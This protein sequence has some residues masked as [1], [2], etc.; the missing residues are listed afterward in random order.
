MSQGVERPEALRG[1]YAHCE[2]LAREGERDRWLSA[3]FAGEAAR[4]HFHAL[5]AFDH[6]IA[7]IRIV[8]RE[9][10]A[11]EM[12][13]AWWREAIGGE[14]DGEARAHPVGAALM[15]TIEAF[16]LPRQAFENLLLARTFDLYDDPMPTWRDLEGYCGE[17]TSILFQCAALILGEGRDL[18]A[19]EA[20]GHAGVAAGVTN[21]L[22]RFAETSARGQVYLPIEVLARHDV[23]ADDVRAR[24]DSAGLRAVLAELAGKARRHLEEAEATLA[25]LP[26][27]VIPAY[28]PLGALR[29]DLARLER[30]RGSPFEPF[31]A[32][33]AWRR[34]W[35]LWRWARAQRGG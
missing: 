14:R 15:D 29:L 27:S 19:A 34:Q 31:A 5:A 1:A 25:A 18:G 22:R 6:E 10:L 24:R 20:S 12:R 23:S 16:A 32:P 30:R 13:L 17:T 8:A 3:L 26:K 33:A 21:V 4:P 35:A 11:G 9:P 7:R 2:A 28:V